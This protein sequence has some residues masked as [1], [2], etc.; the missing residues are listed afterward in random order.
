M[1]LDWTHHIKGNIH[2]SST[3][4]ASKCLLHFAR[5]Y[6]KIEGLAIKKVKNIKY[7]VGIIQL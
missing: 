7:G 1:T 2:H 4:M 5:R 3:Q 6:P